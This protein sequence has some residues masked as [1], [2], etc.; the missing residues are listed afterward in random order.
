MNHE[1]E[2]FAHTETQ[3]HPS[4]TVLNAEGRLRLENESGDEPNV[5]CVGDCSGFF[6]CCNATC[7]CAIWG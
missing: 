2:T 7:N 4:F 6:H 5:P 1:L 3:D